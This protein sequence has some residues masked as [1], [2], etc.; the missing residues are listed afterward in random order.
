MSQGS[1]EGILVRVR[2][3]QNYSYEQA[4]ANIIQLIVDK[5]PIEKDEFGFTHGGCNPDRNRGWNEY[6]DEMLKIVRG[7]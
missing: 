5:M 1:I 6:R 3:E 2:L 7:L 4:K